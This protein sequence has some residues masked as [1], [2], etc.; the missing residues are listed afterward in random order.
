MWCAGGTKRVTLIEH[1][2]STF[3]A[4]LKDGGMPTVVVDGGALTTSA[5]AVSPESQPDRQHSSV[6]NGTSRNEMPGVQTTTTAERTATEL[7]KATEM[8]S[9][10]YT[11]TD[12]L[13]G[14]PV[15]SPESPLSRSPFADHDPSVQISSA[16]IDDLLAGL[17][18]SLLEHNTVEHSTVVDEASVG[19]AP[20]A[21]ESQCLPRLRTEYSMMM[22]TTTS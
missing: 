19:N 22:T 10:E 5:V 20:E 14:S 6:A 3:L 15:A 18:N 12:L 8:L 21:V 7:L 16:D 2:L 4:V 11:T 13:S 17:P 9:P 1:A